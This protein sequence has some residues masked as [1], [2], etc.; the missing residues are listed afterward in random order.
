MESDL[1][2]WTHPWDSNRE[3][4]QVTTVIICLL[5]AF[6]TYIFS[7]AGQRTEV[8]SVSDSRARGPGLIPSPGTYFGVSFH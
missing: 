3:S 7:F 2:I 6:Y 1:E 5:Y 4:A 8:S